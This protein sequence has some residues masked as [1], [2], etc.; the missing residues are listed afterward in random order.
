MKNSRW[1]AVMAAFTLLFVLSVTVFAF[2]YTVE[3]GDT[4]FQLSQRF[5]VTLHTIIEANDIEDPNFIVSGQV[6][7]IPSSNSVTSM[8]EGRYVNTATYYHRL[9]SGEVYIMVSA[10]PDDRDLAHIFEA[11][12]GSWHRQPQFYSFD[13]Y[14]CILLLHDKSDDESIALRF[15]VSPRS[16]V[17]F[18]MM[19]YR[20]EAT[21]EQHEQCKQEGFRSGW[22]QE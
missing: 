3:P 22:V 14:D 20:D 19:K 11:K 7:E 17:A 5:D 16:D 2:P 6:L 18:G 8:S 21:I 10:H 4:L 12:W 1:F 13:G 15:F 9:E